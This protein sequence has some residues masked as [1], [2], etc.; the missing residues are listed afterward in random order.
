MPARARRGMVVGPSPAI[1]EGALG[2]G[3]EGEG[4][5]RQG[6]SSRVLGAMSRQMAQSPELPHPHRL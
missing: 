1:R 5:G 3:E 6:S 2:E 4:T